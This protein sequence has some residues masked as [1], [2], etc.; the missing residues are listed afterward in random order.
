MLLEFVYNLPV[1]IDR[2]TSRHNICCV[3]YKLAISMSYIKKLILPII[4]VIFA[5]R[6]EYF[7]DRTRDGS[8][9]LSFFLPQK[10]QNSLYHFLCSFVF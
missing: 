7:H 1:L 8:K 6:V 3:N 10:H 4:I 2:K 5:I 9:W